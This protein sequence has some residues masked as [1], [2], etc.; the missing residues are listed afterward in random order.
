MTLRAEPAPDRPARDERT[1]AGRN[2]LSG[3]T[4]I[5]LSPAAAQEL[6]ADPFGAQGVMVSAL[7]DNALAGQLGFQPGDIVR[8]INGQPIKTTADLQQALSAS[9]AW[10]VTIQRG[11]QEI[12]GNFRL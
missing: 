2:P 1:I 7:A 4:V 12:A 11:Q 9:G 5:N 10:R 6:G 8:S 3:A